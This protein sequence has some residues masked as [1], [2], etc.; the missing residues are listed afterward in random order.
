MAYA[1]IE[2]S[3]GLFMAIYNATKETFS[4]EVLHSSEPVLVDFW[5]VWCSP[6]RM[7]G[8]TLEEFSSLHPDQ[9]IVK[10]NVDEEPS[11]AQTYRV[12][13]IPTL[14]LFKNGEPVDQKIGYCPL[15]EI[16][17]FL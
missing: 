12:M 2:E 1:A 11:L 14:L 17:E 3:K 4:Q 6:C 16:E 9:K 15:E 7:M 8:A 10:I 13:S 5:A